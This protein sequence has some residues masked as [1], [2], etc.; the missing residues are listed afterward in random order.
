MIQVVKK[1]FKMVKYTKVI[2]QLKIS[3]DLLKEIVKFDEE[4]GVKLRK[5]KYSNII[6]E[7]IVKQFKSTINVDNCDDKT[8]NINIYFYCASKKCKRRW[9]LMQL[10]SNIIKDQDNTFDFFS[11]HEKCDHSEK[12]IRQLRGSERINIAK[13]AKETSVSNVRNEAML[14]CDKDSLAKGNL[15]KIYT[16]PVIRKA[17]SEKNCEFDK[18]L[19]PIYDI[20]LTAND[21]DNVH[22]LEMKKD[23]FS[24]T[25]LSQKQ[26]NVCSSYINS[27][28]KNKTVSRFYYDATGGILSNMEN[29]KC[30]FHHIIVIPWKFNDIDKSNSFF[31]VGELITILHTSDQQEIFLRKFLQNLRKNKCLGMRNT[32][33]IHCTLKCMFIYLNCRMRNF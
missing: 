14:S 18:S 22:S 11:T 29:S 28:K 1:S 12:L 24:I 6:C 5:N 25:F 17:M 19:D 4:E 23:K 21:L 31:N 3:S 13:L 16:K 30:F 2:G 26:A 33:G 9:K 7:E 8:K 20:Y 10:K 27:C 32:G 15:Q